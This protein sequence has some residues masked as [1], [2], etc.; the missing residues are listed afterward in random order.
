MNKNIPLL[1]ISIFLLV[2]CSPSDDTVTYSENQTSKSEVS[3]IEPYSIEKQKYVQSC[4]ET[5]DEG[6]CSCQFDV[7]DPIL[8]ASIGSDWSTKNMEENDFGTYVSAVESAVSQ[9]G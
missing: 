4:L 5:S 7:M 6:F 8:S 1:L 3:T 2:A 9:C